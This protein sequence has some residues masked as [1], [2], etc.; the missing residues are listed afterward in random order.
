ME[1][2]QGIARQLER[3]ERRTW[4]LEREMF[5][6]WHDTALIRQDIHTLNVT[7][8]RLYQQQQMDVTTLATLDQFACNMQRIITTHVA[9]YNREVRDI[10]AI[11]QIIQNQGVTRPAAG[12]VVPPPL[13]TN[14]TS[15]PTSSTTEHCPTHS[16]TQL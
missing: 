4:H 14:T 2:S 12:T 3:M 7:L 15:T 9:A 10:Q 16:P 5:S 8:T 13:G 6:R 11:L 1:L